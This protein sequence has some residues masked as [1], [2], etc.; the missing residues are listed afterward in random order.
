TTTPAV[1]SAQTQTDIQNADLVIVVAGTDAAVAGE[2]TDGSTWA[3]PGN[4]NSL[5]DQVVALGNPRTALVIQSDGPVQIAGEQGKVPA[6]LFSGYNGESQGAALADVLFGKQNPSGHL[7]FTWYSDDSQ[8]PAMSNYGL[9]PSATGGLGRTYMYFT[10]TPTYPFGYGL[11]HTRFRF[12]NLTLN[13]TSRTPN[14]TVNVQF[15]VTNTGTQAGAAVAQI[16]VATP[17]SVSGVQLPGKRL[18]G[19]QKTGVLAPGQS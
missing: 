14:G 11:S 17:F 19:F 15:T 18:E 3:M 7:D 2:G 16:Y 1:L 6:I 13:P 9:T 12:S 8:L 5:I 4:Y 10:G